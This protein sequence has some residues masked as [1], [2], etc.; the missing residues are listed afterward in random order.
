ML[1]ISSL[2]YS[3]NGVEILRDVSLS[4]TKGEFLGIIGPNG[5][6]KTTLLKLML[7]LL[8]PTS[9]DATL[10]GQSVSSMDP[11]GRARIEAYLSQDVMT[12]FPYPVLDIVLMGRYSYLPRFGKESEH[13]IE[14]ARRALAYVGL[15]AF[16]SRLFN[17]LSGGERQLVLFA[18]VLAQDPTLF[19]LDEPTSNL[20]IRHQDQFFSMAAE[21][22]E[23]QKGVIA[24]V[25][26]LDIASRY[27][28]RL[29]LLD[30]GRV[31]ADG[32]PEHVLRSEI[33][34]PVYGINT[35]VS[36]NTAT[37]SLMVDVVPRKW[38][39]EGPRI[40]LVGGGGSAINLTRDLA[41]LGYRLTG[42]VCH[43]YDADEQLWKTLGIPHSSVEPFSKIS[44]SSSG[45]VAAW[46][47]EADYTVLCDFPVGAGNFDNLE[48][49]SSAENLIV[50]EE[51]EGSRQR[52]FFVDE[53]EERL[54]VL[55][56][57]G[58]FL[59]YAEVVS[60]FEERTVRKGS[61]GE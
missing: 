18:K 57:R 25:H 28:S 39:T 24:A 31:A 11:K 4:V 34:D 35:T 52:A 10:F 51:D 50:V 9:G 44:A 49:A 40:H 8:T 3:I 58:R 53:G 47:G 29:V 61:G 36:T 20:D 16:E 45:Q 26:N 15:A 54:Q 37:G 23:E 33:L 48:L 14:E 30:N 2:G 22:A 12:S 7:G 41:R 55:R 13:D 19:V 59:R 32:S 42:G 60:F 56:E 38:G 27:C 5:A 1:S 43:Q 46:I 21:L 6:G 17:E